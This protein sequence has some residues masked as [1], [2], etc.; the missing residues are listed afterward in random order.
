M[1]LAWT[2]ALATMLWLIVLAAATASRFSDAAALA[3]IVF[4]VGSTVCHQLPSRTFHWAG[5]AW[6]VCARCLGLYAA[7]PAGAFAA[8]ARVRRHPAGQPA[9][10]LLLLC[11][12]GIPTLLSWV[13]ERLFSLPVGNV[14]RFAAAL[15]LGAAVAWVLVRTAAGDRPRTVSQYTLGN[16]RRGPAS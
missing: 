2:L 4:R 11:A 15:P 6:P 14:T 10:N 5:A 1:L 9:G 7:A 16:A 13:A 3:D 12:A 8:L